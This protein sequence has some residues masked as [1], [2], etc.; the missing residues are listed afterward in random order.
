MSVL[1]VKVLFDSLDCFVHQCDVS[2]CVAPAAGGLVWS[3]GT[4]DMEMTLPCDGA[5]NGGLSTSSGC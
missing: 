5:V 2:S 3:T 4:G 1:F